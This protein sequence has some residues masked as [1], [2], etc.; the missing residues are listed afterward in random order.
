MITQRDWRRG[1]ARAAVVWLVMTGA[2]VAQ[3]PAAG[4]RRDLSIDERCG[5]HTLARHVGWSDEQLAERLRRQP[6]ISAASTYP[7][8]EIA[9]QTVGRTL[10]R[11]RGRIAAWS[12]GEGRRPN[13]VLRFRGDPR[14][15]PVGRSLRRGRRSSEPCAN[16][17]VVLRWDD[18]RRSFCVLTSY[19]EVRR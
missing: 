14:G 11:E 3:P 9:E 16:A 12:R 6:D 8:R 15:P 1:L 10:Q 2:L 4:P 7:D 13:L 5:G 19:P 17:V 18:R